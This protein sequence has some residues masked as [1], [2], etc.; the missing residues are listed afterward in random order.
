MKFRLPLHSRVIAS[1]VVV[2]LA[3]NLLPGAAYA[4]SSSSKLRAG[5][6]V[7]ILVWKEDISDNQVKPE[8]LGLAGDYL[9]DEQGNIMLPSLGEV[10]AAGQS[11]KGLADNIQ[12]SLRIKAIRIVCLPLIRVTL[13]GAVQKPGSYLVQPKE[14]L[15]ELINKGGGP[16]ND[17]DFRKIKVMRSGGTVKSNLLEAFEKA[18][19]LEDLAIESGDQVIVPSLSGFS[20]GEV[21][22]YAT[23]AMSVGVFYLQ[24]TDRNNR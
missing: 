2:A 1:I 5:D 15:W 11:P 14:S 24:L 18:H 9:L 8:E 4:Q 12:Q 17:A 3:L 6:G 19:S 20:F 16:A 10:K 22:R 21:I 7:R 23:F 13:L